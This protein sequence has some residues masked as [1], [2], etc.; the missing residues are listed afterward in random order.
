MYYIK[1][2]LRY[3]SKPE[4]LRVPEQVRQEVWDK[5]VASLMEDLRKGVIPHW[6]INFEDMKN[7][8]LERDGS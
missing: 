6:V 3:L 8:V 4:E 7:L 1:I 5:R 2:P